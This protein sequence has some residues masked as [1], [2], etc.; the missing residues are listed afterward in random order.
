M[1][2]AVHAHP[3]YVSAYVGVAQVVHHDRATV[4]AHGWLRAMIDPEAAPDDYRALEAIEV[5]ARAHG[6][7]RRLARLTDA[8]GGSFDVPMAELAPIVA[9]APEYTFL[10]Y[11]RL[12]DGMRRGGGPLHEDGLMVTHDFIATRAVLGAPVFFFAGARDFNTSLSLVRAYVEAIEAPYKELVVFE[13]SAHT[14]F[15][16]EPERFTDELVRIAGLVS[17][18]APASAPWRTNP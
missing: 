10:D 14:P 16:A 5:P 15:L 12:L 1:D 7:N 8:Y 18:H 13:H 17:F 6:E 3:G 9:R 11:L 2:L 4:I